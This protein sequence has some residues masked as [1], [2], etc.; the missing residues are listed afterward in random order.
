MGVRLY[1]LRLI[2]NSQ[3]IHN[4]MNCTDPVRASP[5]HKWTLQRW[6]ATA[7]KQCSTVTPRVQNKQQPSPQPPIR[8]H[9]WGFDSGWSGRGVQLTCHRHLVPRLWTPTCLHGV[10]RHTFSFLCFLTTVC[11]FFD[12]ICYHLFIKLSSL[13]TCRPLAKAMVEWFSIALI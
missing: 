11:K 12:S 1:W 10:P 2:H 5:C 8:W 3:S 7:L 9:L 4:P 6:N 13:L